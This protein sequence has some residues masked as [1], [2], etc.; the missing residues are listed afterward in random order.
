MR[1]DIDKSD[2][3]LLLLR[4]D[5]VLRSDAARPAAHAERESVAFGR[6]SASFQ[7][8]PGDAVRLVESEGDL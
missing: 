6:L 4:K 7:K 1:V 2:R 3:L 8:W 5:H